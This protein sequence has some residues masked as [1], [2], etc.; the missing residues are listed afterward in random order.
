M[1][2]QSIFENGSQP[3]QNNQ[4]GSEGQPPAQPAAPEPKP[5]D[6]LLS[7]IRNEQGEVKYNTVEDALTGAAHAQELIAKNKG[8]LEQLRSELQSLREENAEYKGA[9]TAM[10]NFN[11][12][13]NQPEPESSPATETGQDDVNPA[14]LVRQEMARVKLE[15]TSQANTKAVAGA[16][17]EKFGEKAQEKFY[18][19]AGELGLSKDQMNKLAAESPKA[20][21]A[22]FAADKADDIKPTQTS[23]SSESLGQQP[24]I[25]PDAPLPPPERSMLLG[26]SSQELV[27][28]M[29]RH[30]EHIYK[31]FGVTQ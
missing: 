16:L 10:Q 3:T 27:A 19:K 30:K 9:V 2:D 4:T 15:E 24:A 12:P 1:T 28:E 11:Q 8:E 20:V 7:A 21:L 25:N 14:E 6:H 23:T 29:N 22:Y 13:S 5:L 26:P 17:I 18:A 31:K